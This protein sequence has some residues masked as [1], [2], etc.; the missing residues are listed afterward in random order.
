M[1]TVTT[2]T[3][4]LDAVNVMLSVI[5]ESPVSTLIDTGLADVSIAVQIL[6]EVNREI[7]S[8]EWDF[9]SEEDFPFTRNPNGH[10]LV[11][12]NLLKMDIST[13]YMGKYA[14]VV[15]GDKFYDKLNHT[16]SFPEDITADVVWLLQFSDAPEAVRRYITIAAARKFQKRF[17]SSDTLDGFTR[18]DEVIARAEALSQDAWT[19]DF[20]MTANTSVGMILQR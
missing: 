19:A 2:P 5:G 15:R 16:F 12:P 3:S 10:I 7:Q 14:P 1:T 4:E 18:E 17:Y 9:N 20:N 13:K 8:Y 11:P 6:N